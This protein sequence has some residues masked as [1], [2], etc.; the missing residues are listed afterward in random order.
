MYHFLG[1]GEGLSNDFP[2][3][4]IGAYSAIGLAGKANDI[5]KSFT[6]TPDSNQI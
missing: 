6:K 1:D 5:A 3:L 2:L 4:L